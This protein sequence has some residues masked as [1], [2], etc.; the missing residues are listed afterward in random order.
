MTTTG[1]TERRKGLP[2]DLRSVIGGKR[3]SSQSDDTIDCVSPADGVK[4]YALP[5]GSKADVDTAVGAARSAFDSGPWPHFSPMVRKSM[6]FGFADLIDQHKEELAAFD[7]AEM[8]K[9]I[10][11]AMG[12]LFATAHIIRYYAEFADKSFGGTAPSAASL[13]QYNV[14]EPRGVVAAMVSWN[15]PLPNAALK[16]GPALAAGNTVVLKPSELASSSSLRLGE[17][18]AQAGIPEGVLNVVSGLGSTIG[19]ALA[20]HSGVD[21]VAFTGSTATGRAI[22]SA[23]GASRLKALQ[24]ECGGKSATVV[25]A[26]CSSIEAAAQDAAQRIFTNQG[27]LCVAGT[28]L[29]VEASIKDRIVDAILAAAEALKVGD[30]MDADTTFGPLASRGR[31]DAVLSHI[32]GAKRGGAKLRKG[33]R[34]LRADSGGF[35]VEP[36]VFDSVTP[37]MDIAQ[38]DIFGPV[39]S[40]MT[41]ATDD[42][43]TALANSTDYGLSATVWTTDLGTAHHMTKRIRAG[44]VT[45]MAAPANPAAF[46]F[47]MGA[48]PFGQSGFGAE[49]SREGFEAFTRLKAIEINI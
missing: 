46:G 17:L 16:I 19:S 48:E 15:Y 26:D 14:R 12:D 4:L 6:L 44:R 8:G 3:V 40:V 27:Q 42:E 35:F 33:G 22:V 2:F 20:A 49:G 47:P 23:T 10:S 43:A 45:V 24:L 13:V 11:A 36:T 1:L 41:F 39:L 29:I 34:Q 25:F 28:R 31:M 9:P 7:S 30:P 38:A 37:D 32:D 21:F 5:A 18:A